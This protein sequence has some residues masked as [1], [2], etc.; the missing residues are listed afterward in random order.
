MHVQLVPATT[1]PFSHVSFV[2][3]LHDFISVGFNQKQTN[4]S[5]FTTNTAL[6]PF[7]KTYV[8]AERTKVSNMELAVTL[9]GAPQVRLVISLKKAPRLQRFLDI[10]PS[11]SITVEFIVAEKHKTQ[12]HEIILS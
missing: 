8:S 12:I 5:T 9:Q 6:L 4:L 3:E 1:G 10:Q 11:W 7:Y 2:E